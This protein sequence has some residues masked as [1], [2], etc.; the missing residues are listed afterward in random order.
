MTIKPRKL[1]WFFQGI[2]K[3]LQWRS[4][5]ITERILPYLKEAKSILDVGSGSCHIANSL[6]N[7]GYSVV[8]LDISNESYIE[9]LSPILYSGSHIPF[10]NKSFDTAIIITVLHHTKN[11]E[12]IVQEASRVAT[13]IVIIEDVIRNK[14]H[15]YITW[16]LDSL[17]NLEF[18]GHPHS[19]KTDS[20]WRDVFNN[21]D[22]EILNTQ[23]KWSFIFMYQIT[24][25][26][27]PKK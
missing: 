10:E 26:L 11:P 20:E 25:H 14:F 22:L 4:Q 27:R 21:L 24:Y 19:N 16:F 2:N 3:I 7:K 6:L 18:L 15:K 12:Q 13:E 23:H 17:L 1:N 5:E 9:D 8:A